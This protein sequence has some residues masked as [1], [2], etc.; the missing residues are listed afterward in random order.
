MNNNR[1][2]PTTDQDDEDVE[3]KAGKQHLVTDVTKHSVTSVQARRLSLVAS[4]IQGAGYHN[5]RH[6]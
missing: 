1:W 5:S 6:A 4:Q 2:R 3:A